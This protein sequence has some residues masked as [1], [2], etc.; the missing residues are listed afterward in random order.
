MREKKKNKGRNNLRI[1]SV[2]IVVP[3]GDGKKRKETDAEEED[4][5]KRDVKM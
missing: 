5:E 2:R 4:R 3:S 1:V